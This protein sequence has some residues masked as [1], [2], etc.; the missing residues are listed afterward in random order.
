M[1]T[2]EVQYNAELDTMEVDAVEMRKLRR[3][4]QVREITLQRDNPLYVGKNR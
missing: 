1:L 3:Y 4:E 2:R